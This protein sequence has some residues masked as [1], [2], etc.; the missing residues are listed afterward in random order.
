[1]SSRS[2]FALLVAAGVC[3]GTG[4][5]TG[6]ALTEV[7]HVSAPAV[8]AYRLLLGGGLLVAV[9][10]VVGRMPRGSRA[11]R[12]IGAVAALAAAFQA[13][14]FGAVAI[15]SVTVATL[16]AIGS[17]PILVVVSDAL[18]TRRLP[19]SA[20]VRPVATGVLGLAL[21]V[22]APTGQP[23]GATLA[24]AAL[25][26]LA[27]AGFALLTLLGRRPVPEL[28]EATST[29]YGFLLG[30]TGLA[31]AAGTTAGIGVDLS[32]A[33]AALLF[34]L[35]TV[36]TAVA[37]L[38]YFRGLRGSS[39]ATATVV[40]LLEPLTAAALAV[41]LLGECLSLS[42]AAGAA[43]LLASVVDVGVFGGERSGRSR[44]DRA[45]R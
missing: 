10:L 29:G 26:V 21:L 2:S 30:G 18:S 32:L 36:P 35:A 8:A 34:L 3:W 9:L 16:I 7:G 24:G 14:Y 39:A 6:R 5:V 17:A 23:L 31:V 27:G 22:G 44:A 45:A 43:L 20:D 41:T 13:C 11:W 1:M 19:T 28:D 40:A 4:G 37:Y 33:S 15:S 12:R 25:S 42:A 38:L